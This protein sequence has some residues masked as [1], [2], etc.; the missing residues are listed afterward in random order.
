VTGCNAITHG[1]ITNSGNTLTLTINSP[2]T[3]PV[4]IQDV[5]VVWNHDKGHQEG[6][7]KLTLLAASI[8]SPFW[9]GTSAGP[10]Q[11]ITPLPAAYIPTGS[12][13]I[14]FTFDQSYDFLDTTESILINFSTPGCTLFPISAP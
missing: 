3:T 13:T 8:T 1:T 6:N 11:T 7:K 12:S 9:S 10:S 2:V 14:T 4:Q 5:F